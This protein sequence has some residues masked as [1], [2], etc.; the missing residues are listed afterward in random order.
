M[1]R[2]PG[3]FIA[4]AVALSLLVS[5]VAAETEFTLVRAHSENPIAGL[6]K[7]ASVYPSESRPSSE[8]VTHKKKPWLAALEILVPI[9]VAV[10]AF[11]RY[12]FDKG[13]PASAGIP[14]SA[15]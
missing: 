4:A 6:G 10:W 11:D 8:V 5:H 15:T 3:V 9:N 14:G 13:Y 7:Y 2:I 12:V 1:R